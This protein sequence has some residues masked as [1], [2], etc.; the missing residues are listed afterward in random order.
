MLG[1]CRTNLL[2]GRDSRHRRKRAQGE[3]SR[4]PLKRQ[5]RRKHL[6][7]E[8]SYNECLDDGK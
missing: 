1:L 3:E 5:M 4:A 6:G 2:L 8:K 7:Y